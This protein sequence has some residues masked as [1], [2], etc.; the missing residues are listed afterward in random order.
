MEVQSLIEF[1]D[2]TDLDYKPSNTNHFYFRNLLPSDKTGKTNNKEDY[3]DDVYNKG[4]SCAMPAS[5]P[6]DC[7]ITLD[8][9]RIDDVPYKQS[10]FLR[11]RALCTPQVFNF[12][13]ERIYFIHSHKQQSKPVTV[14]NKAQEIMESTDPIGEASFTIFLDSIY[15]TPA[16]DLQYKCLQHELHEKGVSEEII[17]A[18]LDD[19]ITWESNKKQNADHKL[20]ARTRISPPKHFSLESINARIQSY[21]TAKSPDIQALA[22]VMVSV[23]KRELVMKRLCGEE[24]K[25]NSRIPQS[26][27]LYLRL[28]IILK[29][30]D[31][32]FSEEEGQTTTMTPES[33]PY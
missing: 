10:Y 26:H 12:E 14:R 8:I 9:G 27:V 22:D 23:K 33:S 18:T 1:Q 16:I 11:S 4:A 31:S 28:H 7:S 19:Y 3:D 21:D 25:Q 32:D 15:V 2:L 5:F 6:T 20:H 13:F 17:N 24:L 30:G 29:K